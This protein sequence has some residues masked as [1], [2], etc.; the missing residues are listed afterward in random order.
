[1]FVLIYKYCYYI[2]NVRERLNNCAIDHFCPRRSPGRHP[3]PR[4]QRPRTFDAFLLG[5]RTTQSPYRCWN[6]PSAA[7]TRDCVTPLHRRRTRS[8]GESEHEKPPGLP[9]HE[10]GQDPPV[11]QFPANS[12]S[13]GVPAAGSNGLPSS[14]AAGK[15]RS[16]FWSCRSGAD[17][18]E[19]IPRGDRHLAVLHVPPDCTLTIKPEVQ[20]V[21]IVGVEYCMR[22]E[23][24]A[25]EI[26]G[27]LIEDDD[28]VPFFRREHAPVDRSAVGAL[29]Q[30]EADVDVRPI[31]CVA[32]DVRP[33]DE[34]APDGR[35]HLTKVFE[36]S[37][38][39]YP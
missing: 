14:C 32:F 27:D 38:V 19:Q 5:R 21:R 37:C 11:G 35:Q 30:D 31:V 24:S 15:R 34:D 29:V 13:A 12:S 22:F 18:A 17:A 3:S 8:E 39:D 20:I 23:D 6:T 28:I 16:L 2:K 36:E 33:V 26:P 7:N 9:L 4:F 10:T 1:M 25:P